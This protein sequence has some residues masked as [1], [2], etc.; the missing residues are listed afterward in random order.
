MGIS[1]HDLVEMAR[2]SL[3]LMWHPINTPGLGF[4]SN[5]QHHRKCG[6]LNQI[7]PDLKLARQAA[8]V[9]TYRCNS[10]T[11][12]SLHQA[13][14]ER[15]PRISGL[16]GRSNSN[17]IAAIEDEL[18]LDGGAFQKCV[19]IRWQDAELD[20]DEIKDSIFSASPRRFSCSDPLSCCSKIH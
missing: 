20:D 19:S 4:T 5:T 8:L 14:S 6:I 12:D 13:P 15:Q 18:G 9:V 10:S 7:P 17:V 3:R 11:A 2:S 16:Q 1:C